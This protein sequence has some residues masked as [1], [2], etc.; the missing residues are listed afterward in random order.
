MG[1]SWIPLYVYLY[2][3]NLLNV[4]RPKWMMGVL[5]PIHPIAT[6]FANW[7]HNYQPFHFFN[8]KEQQ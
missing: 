1:P 2:Y 4:C 7:G 3:S 8:I 6:I 5:R